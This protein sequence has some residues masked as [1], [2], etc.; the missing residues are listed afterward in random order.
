MYIKHNSCKSL[1]CGKDDESSSL[2]WCRGFWKTKNA[3]KL[4]FLGIGFW[5]AMAGS[6][7]RPPA[8]KAGAL[9]AE[10]IA[11]EAVSNVTCQ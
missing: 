10:L 1:F 7:H 6:N 3:F 2:V 8:C 4:A 5:W 11:R 9:P